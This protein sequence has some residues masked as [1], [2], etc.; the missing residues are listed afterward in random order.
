MCATTIDAVESHH[1]REPLSRGL[2]REVLRERF[3]LRVPTEV[4]RSMLSRLEDDRA[5]VAT[6]DVLHSPNHSWE[7]K[8]ADADLKAK[9]SKTYKDAG[10][11]PPSFSEAFL[12]AGL[13]KTE[14][15]HGRKV[16]Q[17]LI[18]AGEIVR[19]HG[20]LMFHRVALEELTKTLKSYAA[21]REPDRTIDV[22]SFKELARISRKYAI[23]LLEFLDRQRVTRREGDRRFIV[24]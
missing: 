8:G 22:A 3:F 16:L 9:L 14:A 5:L 11:E 12:K 1:K 10:L 18:D 17:L 2:S 24:K 21:A 4:F 23:P 19:V 15:D 20:E 7:L 6:K 13:G